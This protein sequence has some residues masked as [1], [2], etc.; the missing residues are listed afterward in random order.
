MPATPSRRSS[1]ILLHP[2]SLPGP[3]GIGDLGREAHAWVDR[4]AKG[5]VP[6][7]KA[8][9]ELYLATVCRFPSTEEESRIEELMQRAPSRQEAMAGLAWALISSREFAFNH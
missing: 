1:G 2:I 4:L 9:E 6:R 3:F 8:I 5:D 7:S